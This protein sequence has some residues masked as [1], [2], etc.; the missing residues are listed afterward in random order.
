MIKRILFSFILTFTFFCAESQIYGNEWINYSQQYFRIPIP[1]TGLYRI[2]STTLS[3]SGF[4]VSTINPK[5]IQLFIKGEE[6]HIYIKGESDNIFNGT[7]YLE[8]YGEKNDGRYDSLIYDNLT[9][10]PNPY[11]PIWNDTNCA[12]I[13]WNNLTSNKRITEI[14][15][16]NFSGYTASNYFYAEKIYSQKAG[17]APGQAYIEGISDPR[18]LDGEGY[19]TPLS[20][21]QSYSSGTNWN[22]YS[23]P[24]LPVFIQT[25][26][27]GTSVSYIGSFDHEMSLTFKNS[28]GSTTTILDT[29][30]FGYQAF[31][32]NR[33]ISADQFNNS[34]FVSVNN[35]NNSAFASINSNSL[36]H[37]LKIKYPQSLT[38]AGQS[39]QALYVDDQSS[40]SKSFL[41][42]TNINISSGSIIFYDLT[43][44]KLLRGSSAANTYSVLVPNSGGQKKCF[45]TNTNNI[46][47]VNSITPVNQ[48]GYFVDYSTN[49]PDSAFV[50]I[51]H[52]SLASSVQNYANY[53]QSVAGGSNS[54][55]TAYI[56]DLYDQFAYGNRKNPLAIKQFCRY[57]VSVLNTPPKYLFLIGKGVKQEEVGASSANWNLSIVPSM[58]YPSSDNLITAGLNN[59]NSL[60]PYIP[61]GR[62]AATTN[63]DVEHYLSKV[64]QH[65][66]PGIEEWKKNVLHFAGGYDQSQQD[67]FAQYLYGYSEIIK[68]TLFGGTV[69]TFKKT[70]TAP[71][72]I[73]VS[74]SVKTLINNGTSLITLFGHGAVTG[75]D[76]AIDN[77]DDYSNSGKYFLML[78]NSCYSGDIQTP[79]TNSASENFVLADQK[80][81]IAFLASSSLGIVYPLNAYSTEIY[82]A[83]SYY[84]YNKGVGDIVKFAC[85][86]NSA[87]S[88]PFID[89]TCLD[90]TLHGDPSV[91]I[92]NYPHP[93]YEIKNS[94][95]SF[96][97]KTYVDSIGIKMIIKNLA[98]A[99]R[100]TFYVKTTYYLPNG[101]TT[102]YFNRI[103]APLYIDTL[104]FYI[105][106]DFEKC[107]GLNKFK[108]N[109]DFYDKITELSESNNS[110]NGTVDLF[111]EGGDIIPV[112]PYKYAIIP[113]TSQITL[114]AST[115]DPFAPSKTY[116]LQLDTCDKFNTPI[117][118]TMVQSSGGVVEWTVNLP[119][120]DSTVYFWR[121]SKDSISPLETY[122]W[123]E[124]SFMVYKDKNGWGQSH[125]HQ[126]KN[127]FYKFVQYQKPQRKFEFTNDV[128]S[129]KCRNAF[130]NILYYS[131]IQYSI[132]NGL[133]HDW[134]YARDGWTIAVFDPVTGAPWTTSVLTQNTFASPYNNCL[135]FD[136]QLFYAFDFGLSTDCGTVTAAAWQND[137]MNFVNNIPDS[138]C[139]LAYSSDATNATTY[140]NAMYQAFESFGSAQ[141][142]YVSD[143]VP[144]II[145]GKK[146]K[147]IG[148]AHEVIGVNKS[149][150][151]DLQDSIVT[152]WNN[153][154][155]TS[156]I[157]GP[158]EKWNSL[159][160]SYVGQN[161]NLND[162]IIIKIIGITSNG[163]RDT[164]PNIEFYRDSSDV[165]DLY[166]YIDA[167][168]YPQIQLVALLKDNSFHLAPQMK[169]WQVYYDEAPECAIN[170]LKG[171]ITSA[172]TL[173]EGDHFIVHLPIEN[174][175]V[176]PFND[177]LVISYWLE[178]NDHI[179][180]ALPDQLKAKPFLPTQIITDTI[181]VASLGYPNL[182]YLW[183]DVN[184]PT[185]SKYQREQ[186]HFNNIARIPFRVSTDKINPLL[187]VTFDG[188]HILNNDII[189]SK[190]H[191]LV[192]LKD[193]NQ[194]LALN[195]TS[196]FILFLKKPTDTQEK[197]IY[198]SNT[199]LFTPAQLPN[200]SC[201]IEWS[202]EFA[203]DGTY[204]LIVQAKDRSNN[205]SGAIDYR[206]QF[207]IVNKQT[208]TEV[209]NYPNPFST[210]TRFVFTLTGSEIPD[211]FTIQIMTITGK[212]V[213]EITKEQLGFIHIGRNITQYA[214]D[215]KDDFGDK[216]ANGVYLYRVITR[217]HGEAVEKMSTDADQFFKKN[218]GKMVIMR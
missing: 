100:D 98:K 22:I 176:L 217:N 120:G 38:L 92:T 11:L 193:E 111:I 207:E 188:V 122:N 32:I 84:Q 86:I 190:P 137:F 73:N 46:S 141:I 78:A 113:N 119:F 60:I 171:Y 50:I 124:S 8:F 79:A 82:R 28:N 85:T 104:S 107:V 218:W 33:Q 144:M 196:D 201:K 127:D 178:D 121:V 129:V 204:V 66:Q 147:A 106:K 169:K 34:S 3:N 209:L 172:D 173:Q 185:N 88:D 40:S 198:F 154:F 153:G 10:L 210:N 211:I 18:Y 48:T 76:Q 42:I 130:S 131:D 19:G 21:G 62:L 102:I 105:F 72:Q 70:S 214:W 29:T 59:T 164:I 14:I 148:S 125:F 5:N 151:I 45:L 52:A 184:S 89:I 191:V 2:D 47:Q 109:I 165:Y 200:N 26:F 192:T 187:D 53:R 126:F 74:D 208:I 179:N 71:I 91:K 205:N 9:F 115:S 12:F 65:E 15:D 1:K 99:I 183:V 189:S 108:I 162:T 136:H 87:S 96:D 58:G 36:V 75:F 143:T 166:N 199:L 112:Y 157:I 145:F 181:S 177:S 149:A 194:F 51:S 54:V 25:N 158:A 43:N 167:N 132:N 103:K 135:R 56:D 213:R 138:A 156:E 150:V 30:F 216:L 161:G 44:H 80:G 24:A 68:D 94:Y 195:D 17:Y 186:Y 180:H 83:I 123:R 117:S 203:T 57:L 140:S 101:D 142:R 175:G 35:V 152:K 134:H 163:N 61:I 206:I 212:V 39:E 49:H 31:Q 133:M 95:V 4:P 97:T 215:G 118:T 202:P 64:I 20:K 41:P 93:D 16:L 81:A 197:R 116:H 159:H 160:W 63:N 128:A 90:M 155:I 37:F 69:Y 13:T 139:V 114:K 174:I 7:D 168:T 110:T 6:Q 182:N 27:V 77:V 67:S 146:G 23:S 170:A 55:I